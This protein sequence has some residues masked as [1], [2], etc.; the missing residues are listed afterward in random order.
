MRNLIILLMVMLCS[1]CGL[2]SPEITLAPQ[3]KEKA[4]VF[5]IDGTLTP[6]Q[7]QTT[8]ARIDAAN[9]VRYFDEKGYK[10]IYLSAR[11]QFLQSDLPDWLKE[12]G[13]PCGDIQVPKSIV[14]GNHQ[15]ELYKTEILRDYIKKGWMIELAFGDSDLDFKAYH[16]ANKAYHDANIDNQIRIFAL[17]REGADHCEGNNKE[18]CQCMNGWSNYRKIFEKY[19]M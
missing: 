4:V 10:I 2:K 12:K 1:G 8:M 18:W 7:I 11:L 3:G 13:F 6:N 5:D 15:K 17:Q 19:V 16:N 14:I 9:A